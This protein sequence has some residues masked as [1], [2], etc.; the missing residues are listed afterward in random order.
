[1]VKK[2]REKKKEREREKRGKTIITIYSLSGLNVVLSYRDDVS[3]NDELA[4]SMFSYY[5][6]TKRPFYQKII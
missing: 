3:P 1:M 6:I 4:D 2:N 5:N